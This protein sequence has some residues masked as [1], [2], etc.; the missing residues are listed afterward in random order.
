VVELRHRGGT[1]ALETDELGC[2]HVTAMPK[3]P[4]SFRCLPDGAAARSVATS[5]I[6]L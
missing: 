2:F 1:T 3:G 4:V 6:T 5:W